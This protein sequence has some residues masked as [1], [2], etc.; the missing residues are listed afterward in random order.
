[1]MNNN[2]QIA[3]NV[4][5]TITTPLCGAAFCGGRGT[6]TTTTECVDNDN[7]VGNL[8]S[9]YLY[10]DGAFSTDNNNGKKPFKY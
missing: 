7:G 10:I 5:T 6:G 2:M 4:G 1:M 3:N 8:N 9:D